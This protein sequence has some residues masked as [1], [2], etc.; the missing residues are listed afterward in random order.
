MKS[1]IP[2]FYKMSVDERLVYLKMQGALTE[3]DLQQL[4]AG[5]D[6]SVANRMAENVIGMTQVPLGIASNFRING[7]DYL[8]PMAIEEPSVVAAASHAA[9]LALPDGFRASSTR[10]VMRGQIQL[11]DI[12]DQE[13]AERA[14][15]EAKR[16]LIE[17]AN[18][19]A[20]ILPQIGGGVMDMAARPVGPKEEGMLVVEFFVD[21]RDAM[22]ANTVNTVVEGMAPEVARIA[23]G[24]PL[25][26]IISNLATERLASASVVYRKE[27]IGGEGV[28]DGIVKAYRFAFH[29]PYRAA[30]HNKG[31]MN[32]VTALTMATTNDC[33]AIEAGAHAY[34]AVSGRYLPLSRWHKDPSGNLAGEIELPLAYGLVGGATKTHPVAQVCIKLLGV[35]TSMELAEVGASLGLA[36]NFAALRAL[37]TEG[38]QR[39]HME[40]HARNIAVMAGAKGEMVDKV[41]EILARERDFKVSRAKEVLEE[42]G[43]QG[44]EPDES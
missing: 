11:V 21:C 42:L 22:G 3:G 23:G 19:F 34:A 36:Q 37:A 15:V 4:K 41:A 14:V 35:K 1:Q 33:R 2:G 32:G 38:I 12:A 29:D 43:R 18:G 26:R 39:G 10:P 16:E 13:G 27:A 9:K 7:R 28:V 44:E 8:I 20:D 24:R 40:L 31:I 5:L 30:T 6:I 17:K 25:L